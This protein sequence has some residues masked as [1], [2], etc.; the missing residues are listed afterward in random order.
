MNPHE[1][2]LI[3]LTLQHGEEI[4]R[5]LE[6]IPAVKTEVLQEARG[7]VATRT[8]ELAAEV[9]ADARAAVLEQASAV[10]VELAELT[11][12]HYAAVLEQRQKIVSLDEL[13]HT[14]TGFATRSAQAVLKEFS[15]R[16]EKALPEVVQREFAAVRSQDQTYTGKPDFASSFVGNWTADLSLKR[17]DI[18]GYR[19]GSYITLIDSRGVA[20][21]KAETSGNNPRYGLLSAPGA[22]GPAGFNGTS[23]VLGTTA[24][25]TATVG[26]VGTTT[27]S[28]PAALTFTGKTV[29]GGTFTGGTFTGGAFNGTV[30]A[31]TPAAGTFTS[32]ISPTLKSASGATLIL[33][34]TDFGTSVTIASATGIPTF[35]TAAV[36]KSLTFTASATEVADFT[37]LTKPGTSTTAASALFTSIGVSG[38][39]YIGDSFTA[40][41]STNADFAHYIYNANAGT[42]AQATLYVSN[43]TTSSESTFIGVNGTGLTTVGGFVQDGG[44]LGTGTNLSGG[45]SIMARAASSDVRIYAG[46]HTNLI[47]TFAS[48]GVTTFTGNVTASSVSIGGSAVTITAVNSVSPTSPNRTVTITYGGTTLYLAAKTTND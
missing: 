4:D 33:G 7:L 43:A 45:F 19:G 21:S 23:I 28:L 1:I 29:T 24:E 42:G 31:T 48:T 34:T 13:K 15:E 27:V 18:F 11:S 44:F 35:A 36:F 25:I 20:P 47:A 12:K 26:P 5:I 32:L 9:R 39:L 16:T 40:T 17:G 38:A 14:L 37:G 3:D 8:A 6:A 46:S 2:D 22:P 10:R 41:K 30:G